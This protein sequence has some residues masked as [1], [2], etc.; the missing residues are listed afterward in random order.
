MTAVGRL[1]M[2]PNMNCYCQHRLKRYAAKCLFAG[3]FLL[4]ALTLMVPFPCEA[5]DD[6]L[7]VAV[8]AR[9]STLGLSE[10]TP[11]PTLNLL[12]NWADT[13]VY[14]HPVD[15][16][17]VPC[18]AESYRFVGEKAIEFKLRQGIR[19][20]NGEPFDAAAVQFSLALLKRSNPSIAKSYINKF[21]EVEVKDEQTVQI[22][23]SV[24]HQTA[25]EVMANMMFMF[26][27]KYCRDVGMERFGKH[28]VGTGP[29]Q[30]HAWKN[31]NKILFKANPRYFGGPKGQAKIPNLKIIVIL[32]E[33]LR[34]E[35]LVTG[36]VD[37]I[38]SGAVSSEQ[39][40]YLKQNPNI[41]IKKSDILRIFFILMDADGRSEAG[42]FKDRRVRRAL[43]HAVNK[44]GI[45]ETVL[46]GYAKK[47]DT[48]ATPLHFGYEPHV[49]T[50][51]YNPER[52][53]ALLAEAGYPD[54]FEVAFYVPRDETV[55]E[56]IARDLQAV[57]IKAH[58]KWFGGRWPELVKS[59]AVGEVPL[60][61]LTSGSFSI[62]DAAA[63]L[64]LYFKPDLPRCY[65]SHERLGRLLDEADQ[66][67]DRAKR[68]QYL[69]EA[70]KIIAEQA[71]WVP[72]YYGNAISAMNKDL[73]FD[74]P[75][76][77][78]DRYFTASWKD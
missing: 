3:I 75:Y 23:S 68:K 69:S 58:I 64:N 26:P 73:N 19:F 12:H 78:I 37:L 18:L 56:A 9:I 71:F 17:I 70:Q 47:T 31:E 7:T 4:A 74:P 27:P 54:G 1:M 40:P 13:L 41:V 36:Q 45:I 29:Y 67:V 5:G 6:T 72:L 11:R 66:T 55:A 57:G 33:M 39:V 42:Y 60:A 43:N 25:L 50:Y 49:T 20:H 62:F 10:S 46:K 53:Q 32:E 61:L 65:G 51:P 34:L 44:D 21:H 16:K 30:F 48:A 14:R 2:E 59:L 8:K 76:D 38:R 15:R 77:E 24:N 52:A 28:P 35:A 63:L 22:I